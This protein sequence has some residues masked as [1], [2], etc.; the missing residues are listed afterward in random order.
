MRR[1]RERET[2]ISNAT[3][4]LAFAL[5]PFFMSVYRLFSIP[6][7]PQEGW[8]GTFFFYG[9]TVVYVCLEEDYGKR[10]QTNEHGARYSGSLF[11]PLPFSNRIDYFG[12]TPMD[13]GC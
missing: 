9:R 12:G 1:E 7:R 6:F 10:S 5:Q 3:A 4:L 2:G 11:S 8:A 13:A